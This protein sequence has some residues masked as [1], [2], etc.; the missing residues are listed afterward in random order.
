MSS[1]ENGLITHVTF[2]VSDVDKNNQISAGT[3]HGSKVIVVPFDGVTFDKDT[4]VGA[5]GAG[6][7][8]GAGGSAGAG[9]SHGSGGG[10]WRWRFRP[11]RLRGATGGHAGGAWWKLVGRGRQRRF[12]GRGRHRWKFFG[13]GRERRL[14]RYG[15]HWRQQQ[16][17]RR[18]SRYGRFAR[19]GRS[20]RRAGRCVWRID[21][22][23]R[24][25]GRGREHDGRVQLVRLFLRV[26]GRRATG[27]WCRRIPAGGDGGSSA[28][29][30]PAD[31]R[32]LSDQRRRA[33]CDSRRLAAPIAAKTQEHEA[34]GAVG[35]PPAVV[36]EHPALES[37]CIHR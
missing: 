31:G 10:G 9:G 7:R 33:R 5:G 14:F 4:G 23:Q 35:P 30:P 22:C 21:R 25:D 26:V 3:N 19:V 34:P 8:G 16:Q 20:L 13:P 2:A 1:L 37:R 17:W 15:R 32:S 18:W 11:R 29:R 28:T 6:G 12:V 36:H 24:R 27:P